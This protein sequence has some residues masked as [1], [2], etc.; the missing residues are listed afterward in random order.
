MATGTPKPDIPTLMAHANGNQLLACGVLIQ[1]TLD[2][3]MPSAEQQTNH[4]V[5]HEFFDRCTDCVVRTAAHTR[6]PPIRVAM[7]IYEG[8]ARR[9]QSRLGIKLLRSMFPELYRAGV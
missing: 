3:V 4:R 5:V 9:Q 8:A 2:L 1:M 6:K 7:D